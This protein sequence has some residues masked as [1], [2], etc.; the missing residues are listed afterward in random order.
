MTMTDPIGDMLTRIR[1][2]NILGKKSVAVP[3]SRIKKGIADA[4]VRE[5]FIERFSVELEESQKKGLI[6]IDLK[7]GPDGE[8]VIT[9][10]KRVSK[11][12]RRIYRSVDQIARVLNGFGSEIYTTNKGILSDR[13]CRN[14]KVG[15]EVL[16]MV[17]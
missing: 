4:L 9:E 14:E 15:G 16:L 17:R 10:I 1:N 6:T 11:P 13:E 12:G 2:A 5:G 8:K 7:Y 3:L